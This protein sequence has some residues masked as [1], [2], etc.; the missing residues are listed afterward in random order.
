M[1]IR[2]RSPRRAPPALIAG[3][4]AVLLLAQHADSQDAPARIAL[5]G[6]TILD[7]RGREITR[8]IV[9]IEGGKIARVGAAFPVSKEFRAVDLSGK[10]LIPGLVDAHTHAG[11]FN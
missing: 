6:A 7:G 1:P 4:A 5:T 10:F 8:G 9:L 2:S 3:V 11:V